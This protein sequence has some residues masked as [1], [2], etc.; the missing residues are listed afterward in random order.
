M[1]YYNDNGTSLTGNNAV[2][3]GNT[4]RIEPN[5]TGN[6]DQKQLLPIVL[7]VLPTPT[8]SSRASTNIFGFPSFFFL[9]RGMFTIDQG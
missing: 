8:G 6:N 1:H 4:G 2:S 9:L 3:G 7:A 5:F